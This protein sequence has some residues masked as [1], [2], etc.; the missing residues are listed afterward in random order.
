MKQYHVYI[1]TNKNKTV[2][3]TGV[4]SNL[5]KR[6]Y[7]HKTKYYKGFTAKYNCDKLVYYQEFSNII[8]AI[9]YEKKIK[10]GSRAKKEKLINEINPDWEDLSDGWVFNI[11]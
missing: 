9:A 3:Y 4:T 2:L 11:K 8:E 5:I 7:Q 10:A 6:I 1:T